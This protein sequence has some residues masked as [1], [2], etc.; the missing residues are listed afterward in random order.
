M[1]K[2]IAFLARQARGEFITLSQRPHAIRQIF[3]EN[4]K[5]EEKKENS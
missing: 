4:R 1:H 2:N 5:A 3:L